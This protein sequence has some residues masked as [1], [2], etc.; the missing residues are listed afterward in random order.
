MATREA[1]DRALEHAVKIEAAS[2][3]HGMGYDA[4]RV[5]AVAKV[6]EKYLEP[7]PRDGKGRFTPA[8]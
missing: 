6:F 1:R 8:P 2:A 4:D 3:G 7:R 5:I